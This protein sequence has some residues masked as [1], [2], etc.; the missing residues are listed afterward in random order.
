MARFAPSPTGLRFGVVDMTTTR[1]SYV[2]AY[3]LRGS[4]DRLEVLVLRRGPHGRCPGS[5][6]TVHGHIDAGETP[7]E[8]AL[9]EVQEETRLVPERWYNISRVELFYRQ[10]AD[11]VA[12]IPVF[13]AWVGAEAK[14]VLSPEHDAAEWLRP[15]E[16]RARFAWPRERRALEDIVALLGAGDAGPVEDVLRIH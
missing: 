5:W 13:V 1:V 11:E 10:T 6:E 3:V 2:D 7:S 14:A 16:A 12:L 9:R 4:R 8:A 15:V